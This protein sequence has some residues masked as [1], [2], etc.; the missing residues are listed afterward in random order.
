M[1]KISVAVVVVSLM[2]AV[3]A[4]APYNGNWRGTYGPYGDKKDSYGYDAIPYGYEKKGS[5]GYDT[6]SY[7]YEKK[8]SNYDA[9]P[10]GYD[11]KGS[12]TT[13]Y[14]YHKKYDAPAYGYDKKVSYGYDAAPYGY[15]KKTRYGYE[16]PAYGYDKY[17]KPKSYGSYSSTY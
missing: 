6:P 2:A 17:E 1:T 9:S 16:A 14:G 3:M 12:E 11:G 5:Y 10:Y 8:G 13:S 7:G 4:N 15:D